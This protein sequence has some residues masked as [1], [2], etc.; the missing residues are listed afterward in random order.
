VARRERPLGE[1]PG[2]QGEATSGAAEA[3]AE[4]EAGAA[5]PQA[6]AS[7]QEKA[8]R[9][10]VVEI[11]RQADEQGLPHGSVE[12]AVDTGLR[13]PSVDVA[14]PTSVYS[15]DPQ[16]AEVVDEAT[17]LDAAKRLGRQVPIPGQPGVFARPSG[18]KGPHQPL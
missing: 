12:R 14:D 1:Q 13:D 17:A 6:A 2:P 5:S 18:Q 16:L 7:D 8:R 9:E 11:A 10:R 15:N 4:A 3:E